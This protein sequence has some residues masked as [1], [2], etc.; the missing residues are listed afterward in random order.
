MPKYIFLPSGTETTVDP[1]T[2]ILVAAK[3]AK[4]DIRYGCAS[5][6]CGTCAVSVEGGDNLKP[7]AED[8]RALLSRMGLVTDGQVR[9]ACRARIQEGSVTVDIDFQSTY[10][11]DQIEDIEPEEDI[12]E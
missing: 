8:E 1:T 10:S 5:C 7:M 2:K 6:R 9:L 11:P 12:E 4:V 3:N